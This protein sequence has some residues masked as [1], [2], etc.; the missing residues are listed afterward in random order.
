MRRRPIARTSVRD[1]LDSAI[2]ALTAARCD[3]PRLDAELLL[4]AAM[5]VSRAMIVARPDAE[6]E[7]DEAWQFAE[8]VRR[9][10]DREPVAYILGSK[11]FRHIELKVDRR[12]L[13]PRPETEHLVEAALPLPEGARVVDVGTG[14]GAVALALK[15][16]RPDLSVTGVDLSADALDV[17][18]AN[19]TALRLD[20]ELLHGDLLEPVTG[21]IDAVVS[22]PPYVSA[23]DRG[24]LAAE[25]TRHE[26]QVALFAGPDGLAVYKR[27]VP[28]A[29]QAG[30]RFIAVE[31][32][33]TQAVAVAELL[34]RTGFSDVSVSQDLGGRD[35]IITGRR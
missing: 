22:N 33:S 7:P 2:I 15:H 11:G 19:A 25:V 16:E 6:L 9:R 3:T 27:L 17:A 24:S 1:A 14:S 31:I 35:R 34:Q 29:A 20:V 32:G 10:R 26:P 28:A 12:V 23:D 5:G 8:W 4:A 21:P 30:A 18:R 13:I